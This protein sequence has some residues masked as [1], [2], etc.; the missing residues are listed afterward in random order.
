MED[1][2]IGKDLEEMI[3]ALLMYYPSFRLEGMKKNTK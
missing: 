3:V 1:G 2:L